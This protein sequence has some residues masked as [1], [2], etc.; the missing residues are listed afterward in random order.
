[1]E[2]SSLLSPTPHGHQPAVRRR[3][4]RLTHAPP[5]PFTHVMFLDSHLV[6][7]YLVWIMSL[8]FQNHG[9]LDC[10]SVARLGLTTKK[11]RSLALQKPVTRSFDVFFDL[12]L[13]KR[14]SKQS[15]GWWFETPS[16]PLWRHCNGKRRISLPCIV[17]TVAIDG[18]Q[19]PW[20]VW[21][22]YIGIFRSQHHKS[23]EKAYILCHGFK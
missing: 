19:Q 8:Q 2:T 11:H 9:Q 3:S 5:T 21:P 10:F 17:H 4:M 13:N 22:R 18:H 15:R 6:R 23:S 14:L 7:T 20:Y 16:R 12:C 1:M